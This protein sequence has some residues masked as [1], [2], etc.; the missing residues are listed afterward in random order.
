MSRDPV[1]GQ[2]DVAVRG[3]QVLAR[4]PLEQ[5]GCVGAA[6]ALGVLSGLSENLLGVDLTGKG[7]GG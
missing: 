7:H 6:V 5:G 4:L 1:L 2:A 3:V